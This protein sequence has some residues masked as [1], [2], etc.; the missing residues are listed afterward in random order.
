MA[1]WRKIGGTPRV[2]FPRE[3]RAFLT[4][5][6]FAARIRTWGLNLSLR[7]KN[8]PSHLSGSVDSRIVCVPAVTWGLT[9]A[10]G[11]F[12]LLVKCISSDFFRS[13]VM[14]LAWP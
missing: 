5:R 8:T 12:G 7:S 10:S 3:R 6:A 2:V 4:V 13:K 9:G 11:S 1:R 14:P